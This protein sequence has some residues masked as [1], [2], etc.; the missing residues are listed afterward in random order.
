[1][2]ELETRTIDDLIYIRS[3]LFKGYD[4]AISSDPDF[5]YEVTAPDGYKI[6]GVVVLAEDT[7][8]QLKRFSATVVQPPPPDEH[9]LQTENGSL[10]I[11]ETM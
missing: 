7:N 2:A 8:G 4:S 6:I 11:T 5:D 9:G 3:I 1:V 10:Q